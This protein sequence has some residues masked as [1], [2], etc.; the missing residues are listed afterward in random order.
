MIA[1]KADAFT[2]L[3]ELVFIVGILYHATGELFSMMTM[4]PDNPGSIPILSILNFL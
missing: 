4:D 2:R 1:A 3:A